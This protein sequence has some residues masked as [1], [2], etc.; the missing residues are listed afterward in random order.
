MSLVWLGSLVLK[1]ASL[2]DRFWGLGFC[3]VALNTFWHTPVPS[4]RGLILLS[5]TLLW[6]VR[7]SVYLTQRNWNKGEDRRYVQM[8]QSQG[9]FFPIL[10]L[11]S[12]FGLQ[13]LLCA[14]IA[15]PLQM[16][17]AQTH[18]EE[19]TLWDGVGIL[20]WVGGFLFEIIGD[21]QLSRF[22]ADPANHEKVL[23]SGLWRYTRHPN[24][25]GDALLWWGF[26]LMAT[27]VQHGYWGL[28]GAVLMN[29]L[30]LR[31]SGVPMLEEALGKNRP[32]YKDYIAR[33]SAFI[34]R[35]P[36]PLP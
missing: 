17:I 31:V 33:T 28:I 22:K 5:T 25:F 7:L 21:L 2:V 36:R 11:F 30:L 32:G 27:N 13:A 24:Y 15:L 6:G 29:F 12:V 19:L 18:P 10:S 3:V 14:I 4:L 16:G 26:A 23:Q 20:F 34:P 35:P 9:R 8:R 1:D